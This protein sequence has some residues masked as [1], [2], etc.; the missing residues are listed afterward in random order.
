MKYL[1]G[2]E[3]KKIN[4]EY[5]H[6]TLIVPPSYKPKDAGFFKPIKIIEFDEILIG[7]YE[8]YQN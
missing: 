2:V 1:N 8:L 7:T 3:L 5:P 6:I 4:N